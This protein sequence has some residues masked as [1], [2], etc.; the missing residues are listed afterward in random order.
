MGY[1]ARC[2]FV[3]TCISPD[4]RAIRKVIGSA[5]SS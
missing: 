3:A 4:S 5:I 2:F 1:K